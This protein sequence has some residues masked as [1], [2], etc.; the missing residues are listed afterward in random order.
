M[1]D[2]IDTFYLYVKYI[3]EAY[4]SLNFRHFQIA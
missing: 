2:H 3:M 1:S 4:K